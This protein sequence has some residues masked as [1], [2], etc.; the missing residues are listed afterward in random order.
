MPKVFDRKKHLLKVGFNTRF[1]LNKIKRN[2]DLCGKEYER[3]PSRIGK[4]CSYKCSNDPLRKKEIYEKIALKNKKGVELKCLQCGKLFYVSKCRIDGRIGKNGQEQLRKYC[5]KKCQSL[6]L[7][8]SDEL[9]V[10]KVRLKEWRLKVLEKDNYTCQDCGCT[11]KRLLIA[12]HI[13]FR[14]EYPELTYNL[15]NGQTL[16]IY[17]HI[18][19][20]RKLSPIF[21]LTSLH[22]K[23]LKKPHLGLEGGV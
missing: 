4:Y 11:R 1:K 16:C 12:H 14:K 17:C 9:K 15:E 22:L 19:K 7:K 3:I 8:K 21:I 13:K 5:S 18:K 23:G 6:S 20:H 2:C 10:D